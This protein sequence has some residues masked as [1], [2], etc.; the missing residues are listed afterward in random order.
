MKYKNNDV[1]KMKLTLLNNKD[2]KINSIK[3]KIKST[4]KKYQKKLT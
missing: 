3:I 4:Q 1:I 2:R